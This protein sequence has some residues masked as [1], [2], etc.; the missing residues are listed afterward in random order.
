M[1]SRNGLPNS[2]E[3]AKQVASL[4]NTEDGLACSTGMAALSVA[5]LS[6]LGKG[7]NLIAAND[8]YGGTIVLLKDEL[9]R[10]GIETTF[11][12]AR[13]GSKEIESKFT[14]NAKLVLVETI[15][16][17]SVQVCDIKR[18]A[19]LAH[20]KNALL[21][22]DNTFATPALQRPLKFGADLV[23]H[24]ATKFL[25]GHGDLLGGIIVGRSELID[26][27]RKQGLRVLTGATL[28]P[29]NA[30]LILRGLKTLELR[31]E[32][33]SA[34][35]LKVAERLAIHPRVRTISYPGLASFPQHALAKLQ[36]SRFGGLIS[37]ELEGGIAEGMAFMN[38]LQLITRAVSL[39]DTETLIQHPASMTHATYSA[40]ERAQH[41]ISDGLLRMSVGLETLEDILEDIDQALGHVA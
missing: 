34:S 38:R 41:G 32:R 26:R 7:D 27:I 35:A 23:L 36:M 1:Y 37:F 30:F 22:V 10:F 28:S 19:E 18:I 29:L 4:E 11:I 3:L 2:N 33:H 21:I 6:F 14:E 8:L 40:E 24:S 20:R 13:N 9:P 12:N 31:V 25:G 16:N 17:P 5:M 39:G 15:S